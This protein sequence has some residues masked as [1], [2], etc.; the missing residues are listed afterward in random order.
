MSR[1]QS[2]IL[3]IPLT[4]APGRKASEIFCFKQDEF[5]VVYQLHLHTFAKK[6]AMVNVQRASQTQF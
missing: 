6:S 2:L 4:L 5:Q 3:L 1:L